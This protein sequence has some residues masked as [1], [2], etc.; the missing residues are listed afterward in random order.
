[1]LLAIIAIIDEKIRDNGNNLL[2]Y[3]HKSV[4][5]KLEI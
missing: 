5:I 2:D 3:I 1:M 4:I